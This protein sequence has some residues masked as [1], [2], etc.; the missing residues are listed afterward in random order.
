MGHKKKRHKMTE[1]STLRGIGN[2]NTNKVTY[3]VELRVGKQR[4]ATPTLPFLHSDRRIGGRYGA[5]RKNNIS[6]ASK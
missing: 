3:A 1:S 2:S 4:L 5:R 6:L